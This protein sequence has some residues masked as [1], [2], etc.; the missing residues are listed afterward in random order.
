MLP[1]C[2]SDVFSTSAFL[3]DENWYCGPLHNL[4]KQIQNRNNY[5]LKSKQ[6]KP[7][8]IRVL[9][10]GTLAMKPRLDEKCSGILLYPKVE[11]DVSEKILISGHLVKVHTI[12]LEQDWQLIHDDL[13]QLIEN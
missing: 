7:R 3:K 4:A 10:D 8:I 5:D 2:L 12:D 9:L 13:L 11:E 1:E 6:F